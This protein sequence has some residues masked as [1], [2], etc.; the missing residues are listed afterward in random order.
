MTELQ[1]AVALAQT[2][3]RAG[4]HRPPQPARH[5]A[6]RTARAIPGIVPQTVPAGCRH[7]YFLYLF[8]L[9]L[10][11]LAAPPASLPRPWP[12]KACR[13]TPIKSPAG[14]RCTLTDLFQKRSAFP[15]STYPFGAR[16]YRPETAHCRGRVHPMDHDE[17]LRALHGSDIEEIAFGIGKVARYFAATPGGLGKTR[18]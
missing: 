11:R 6:Q 13:T 17:H 4:D 7:S 9:D 5:A 18:R 10:A 16:E 15:G 3:A 12:Q 1:G 14:G 2:R 8:E